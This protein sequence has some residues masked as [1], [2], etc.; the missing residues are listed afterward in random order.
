MS[1]IVNSGI[2][3]QYTT[4]PDRPFDPIGI[5][6]QY[7]KLQDVPNKTLTDE[8]VKQMATNP[9]V[10]GGADAAKRLATMNADANQADTKQNEEQKIYNM[11]VKEIGYK[12]SDTTHDILD[13]LLHFD[14]SDGMRGF[15]EI[16]IKGD[17]MIYV[18]IIIMMFTIAGL[19]I[20]SV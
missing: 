4:S 3:A 15:L 8:E 18:G 2:P 10:N 14:K 12:V 13:D 9:P 17:R 16:F 19:L 5:R 11:S 7:V 1:M 6:D 20:R